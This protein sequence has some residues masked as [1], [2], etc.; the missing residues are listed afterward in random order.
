MT[1]LLTGLAFLLSSEM[2]VIGGGRHVDPALL[3][4]ARQLE[5]RAAYGVYISGKRVGFEIEDTSVVLWQGA[6]ALRQVTDSEL[7]IRIENARNRMV[8]RETS[9]NALHGDGPVIFYKAMI[10]EAGERV[11]RHAVENEKGGLRLIT[12]RRGRSVSRDIAYPK[13]NL[14][15]SASY[16][17]WLKGKPAVGTR[18]ESWS[19]SWDKDQVDAPVVRIMRSGLSLGQPP[20]FQVE[21]RV[22]G[23]VTLVETT[24]TG[25][26]VRMRIGPM[27][28]RLEDEFRARML[29]RGTVDLIDAASVPLNRDVGDPRSVNRMVLKVEG[30]EG[31]VPPVDSRQ[32]VEALAPGQWRVTLERDTARGTGQPLS[33]AERAAMMSPTGTIQSAD[34]KVLALARQWG[35]DEKRPEALAANI[36]RGVYKYLKKVL[37]ANSEDALTIIDRREGDC[38]EHTLLFVAVARAAGLP[39]REVGGLAYGQLRGKPVLAWH[40]WPEY[41]DGKQW[42]AIDPTWN[43]PDGVD[44]THWKLSVG[45]RDAAW[46]NLMGKLKV[47]VEKLESR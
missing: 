2:P 47:N 12:L 10:D 31:F 20:V 44:G 36:C 46:L 13:A 42:R 6:L 35:A 37:G 38:T 28:L 27:D 11:E 3:A 17:K 21:E 40:A 30:L 22:D 5:G 15:D 24:L 29:D 39:A 1:I 26:A 18:L 8:S 43:E 34:A 32:K 25:D 19:C 7:D 45:D 41:H 4:T 33:A 9:I 14:R 16:L 23:A